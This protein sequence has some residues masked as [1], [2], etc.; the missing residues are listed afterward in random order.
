VAV[1]AVTGAV[2]WMQDRTLVI[3]DESQESVVRRS[4]SQFDE[5]G[6]PLIILSAS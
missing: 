2:L 4:F 1:C 6:L 3:D 5:E